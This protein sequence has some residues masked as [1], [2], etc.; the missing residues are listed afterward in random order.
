MTARRR[1][2]LRAAGGL[3]LV[4]AAPAAALVCT[5]T[6]QGV[7]F[8]PYDTLSA[9][10]TDGVGNVQVACLSPTSFTVSL[11]AGN[12]SYAQRVMSGGADQLE[13]NL[14]IDAARTSVWGDGLGATG[15]L[16]ATGLIVDL[17]IYG[18]I[19]AQQNVTANAYADSITVTVIY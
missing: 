8:G 10:S 4:L 3:M 7:A 14:Y 13:Y 1:W 6:A 9:S 17:P 16:S 11:S 15:N 2:V 18:R 5:A 12:G 19:P